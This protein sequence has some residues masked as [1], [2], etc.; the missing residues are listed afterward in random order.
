M[1]EAIICLLDSFLH[2]GKKGKNRLLLSLLEREKQGGNHIGSN[3]VIHYTKEDISQSLFAIGVGKKG[4]QY[5]GSGR[6][7]KII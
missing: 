3:V 4:V 7:V 2:I 6:D 5:L 1:E